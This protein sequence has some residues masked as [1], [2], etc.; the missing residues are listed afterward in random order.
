MTKL[1]GGILMLVG[2]LYWQVWWMPVIFT[3][4]LIVLAL[5]IE[6]AIIAK[7]DVVQEKLREQAI[8]GTIKEYQEEQS[9]SE[10]DATGDANNRLQDIC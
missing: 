8:R 2:A 10:P 5:G 1:I 9:E 6:W 7:L 3:V 4:G